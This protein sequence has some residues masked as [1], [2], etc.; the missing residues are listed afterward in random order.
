MSLDNMNKMAYIPKKDYKANRLQSGILQLADKTHLVLDET[1]LQPGQLDT[2]GKDL[3]GL[4]MFLITKAYFCDE[5]VVCCKK[6]TS[7]EFILCLSMK[8]ALLFGRSPD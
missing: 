6:T 1:A 8:G 7:P 4:R 5:C 2:N 3:E